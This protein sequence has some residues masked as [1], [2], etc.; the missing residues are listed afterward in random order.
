MGW[1]CSKYQ[2]LIMYWGVKCPNAIW[3]KKLRKDLQ[4]EFNTALLE[5]GNAVGALARSKYPDGV[6][7]TDLPWERSAV[8]N[9][10]RAIDNNAPYIYEATMATSTGE[11]CAVDILKNNND[12]TW[13]IIEVKSTTKPHDYHYIDISFQK[14]VFSKCGLQIRDC[15]ILTLN[16]EYVRH[17]E[18]DAQELFIAHDASAEMQSMETVASEVERIRNILNG[19]ELGIAISKA[20]CNKF[21]E[22]SYKNHCWRNVPPYSVFDAFK[23]ALA[24]EIYAE[25]G[26]D[27]ANVPADQYVRQM[28][29]G[30]IEAFLSNQEIC[31]PDILLNNNKMVNL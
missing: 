15:W 31:N 2:N 29:S 6:H 21:Y 4:P 20:K 8:L 5:Q 27:L 23:V 16:P 14:Y 9:T 30:D 25:Y 3:F 10:Q 26:P 11:Y 22:C 19:P 13:D 12:G 17:G 28:R 1:L 18:L 24:D 7:I